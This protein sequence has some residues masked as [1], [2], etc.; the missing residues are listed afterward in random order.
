M[1][2]RIAMFCW[3]L[4]STLIL[5]L[6][7]AAA[8]R[9]ED[10]PTEILLGKSFDDGAMVV[11]AEPLDVRKIVA[12]EKAGGKLGDLFSLAIIDPAAKQP[13]PNVGARVIATESGL[14]LVP[15]YP[16]RAGQAF[17]ATLR[18]DLLGT[19]ESITKTITTDAKKLPARSSVSQVYPTADK[20]PENQ[21]K[22]YVHFSGAMSR[23][24]V[25][26]H[27]R[28]L[29]AQGEVIVE[30]FLEIGEEFWDGAQQRLTLLVDPGRIKQG[31]APREIIGPVFEVGNRYKLVIDRGLLDAH[32]RPLVS[33]YEKSFEIV[34]PIRTAVDHKSWKLEPLEA[35]S[36]LPLKLQFD[37]SMDHALL[38]RTIEVLGPDGEPVPGVICL[39]NDDRIWKLVPRRPWPAGAYQLRIDTV[40]EDLAGNQLGKAF[41]VDELRPLDRVIDQ[42]FITIDFEIKPAA[43]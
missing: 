31:V 11:R 18:L 10:S 38:Q 20:L 43:K 34:E 40:L 23:G 32:G 37:R 4:C 6:S 41:E 21:L 26:K 12:F 9:G 22:F 27:V 30:P 28:L 24:D 42:K 13:L 14:E 25:Y 3:G 29:D 1:N 35:M 33:S 39:E 8:L 5:A 36:Q 7:S 19:G 2:R 16:L 17:R 15:I